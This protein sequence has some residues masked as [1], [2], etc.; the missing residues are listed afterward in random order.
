VSFQRRRAETA[1]LAVY[2]LRGRLIRR[3]ELDG[4]GA[5]RQAAGLATPGALAAGV[6]LVHLIQGDRRV[7]AKAVGRG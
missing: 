3:R 2:D 1:I 4:S 6:Y 5:L 7:V